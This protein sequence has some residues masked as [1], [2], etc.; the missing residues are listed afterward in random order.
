[1]ITA[2]PLLPPL[3]ILEEGV[4]TKATGGLL[5]DHV[6]PAVLFEKVVVD[7]E[8]SVNVPVMFVDMAFTVTIAVLVHPFGAV[9]IIGAVPLLTPV[10]TPVPVTTVATGMFP[11]L[12]VAPGVVVLKIVVAPVHTDNAPVNAAG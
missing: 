10:T 9:A 2:V 12:H 8:Q 1:V 3:I 4:N 7:P 11:E 6:P 5:L